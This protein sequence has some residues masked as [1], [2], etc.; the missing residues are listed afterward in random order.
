MASFRSLI[1]NWFVCKQLKYL[2]MLLSDLAKCKCIQICL[3]LSIEHPHIFLV[4]FILSNETGLRPWMKDGEANMVPVAE[5]R[6]TRQNCV[7]EE[8][9]VFRMLHRD[10]VLR[11]GPTRY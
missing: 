6:T 5:G 1:I 4:N 7:P 10:P 11:S 9:N 2:E 8:P 3:H